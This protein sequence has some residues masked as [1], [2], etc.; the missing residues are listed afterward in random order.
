M[1]NEFA[2]DVRELT[3]SVNI[4]ILPSG[5]V[6]GN[7]EKALISVAWNWALERDYITLDNPT[8]VVKPNDEKP[9]DHYVTDKEYNIAYQLAEGTPYL[10]PAMELAYLCRMK[11]CEI[12]AATKKHI[13]KEGFDTQRVKGSK[14]AI[15]F[16][17]DRLVAAVNYKASEIESFYIIH[18]RYGQRIPE[19]AFKSAW[20]RLKKKMKKAGIE[21]FNFHDLKAKG[22][23]DFN[24]DVLDAT[25]HLDPKM[26]KVYKRKLEV[27]AT[28]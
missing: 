26:R 2:N 23:T 28:R 9:R 24:G 7:R 8:K 3:G 6:V 21:P 10:R 22:G 19:S 15:T 11:R 5:S 20:T 18:N 16:W 12:L 1:L 4:E 25:G 14:D 27:E 17:S 13:L